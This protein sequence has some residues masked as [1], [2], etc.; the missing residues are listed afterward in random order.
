MNIFFRNVGIFSLSNDGLQRILRKIG[1]NLLQNLKNFAE[2]LSGF[3]QE[4]LPLAHLVVPKIS[5]L[6]SSE[7]FIP[8]L[9]SSGSLV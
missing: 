7:K 5:S 3:C 6:F 2:T 4:L 9:C 1:M 8:N